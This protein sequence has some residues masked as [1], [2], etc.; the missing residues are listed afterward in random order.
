MK[1]F[2]GGIIDTTVAG[3]QLWLIIDSYW[4]SFGIK[5]K[6]GDMTCGTF[7]TLLG[8]TVPSDHGLAY[9]QG[10]GDMAKT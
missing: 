10:S 4:L 3:S 9:V 6:Q 7:Q 5:C 2:P 8:P 1:S